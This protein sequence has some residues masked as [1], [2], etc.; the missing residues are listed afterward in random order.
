MTMKMICILLLLGSI[1]GAGIEEAVL[2][3]TGANC[4]EELSEDELERFY[5]LSDNPV[6]INSA[7]RSRLLSSGLF[8]VYQTASL[9]ERR[10]RGGDILSVTELGLTDGFSPELARA[11]SH[12]V[13]LEP[14]SR[15]GGLNAKVK[16]EGLRQTLVL[17]GSGRAGSARQAAGRLRYAADAGS[18]AS[19][20]MT[21]GNT[22]SDPQLHLPG[23]VSL[24]VYGRRTLSQI[25]I[26][27]FSARFGQGLVVWSGFRMS[28]YS[29]PDSFLL[30]PSGTGVTGSASS[31]LKGVAA[32]WDFGRWSMSAAYSFIGQK[33]I[34]NATRYLSRATISLNATSEAAS[35]DWRTAWHS[36]SIFGEAAVRFD[37]EATALSGLLWVP[38]Y[39]TKAALLARWLGKSGRQYSGVAFAFANGW[40]GASLDLGYRADKAQS[41]HKAQMTLKRE[42]RAGSVTV[43]PA[44]RLSARLRPSDAARWR[45]ALRADC[46]AIAGPLTAAIRYEYT[47][48]RSYAHLGYV[49]SGYK[50]DRAGIWARATLFRIDNWDDRIYV[51]ERDAPGTFNV[52]AY[53]GRGFSASLY[54]WLKLGRR[55]SLWLRIAGISYPWQQERKDG[56]LDASL[57]YRLQL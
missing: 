19:L 55:H 15:R 4:I 10:R 14:S 25:V 27:D 39:G 41:Q 40:L 16:G 7:S 17:R 45:T 35:V 22:L 47:H 21:L 54:A 13:S 2:K 9:L 30:K 31:E 28:G 32:S 44:L 29:S 1:S 12:F 20:R 37:G 57:Q 24:A 18:L 23:T 46:S 3:I 49:E 53:Y 5:S 33:P 48:C 8:S 50:C 56:R 34:I 11:L 52:P 42:F 43:G 36:A 51:Y 38:Q 26:G 6:E